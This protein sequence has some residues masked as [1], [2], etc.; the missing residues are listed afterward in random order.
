[1]LPAIGRSPS[2][3]LGLPVPAWIIISAVCIVLIIGAL[4]I[5]PRLSRG[6]RSGSEDGVGVVG[7]GN[8]SVG[9]GPAAG[10]PSSPGSAGAS[11]GPTGAP[12][13]GNLRISDFSAVQETLLGL[14]VGLGGWRVTVTIENP[15]GT[16]Q[17]WHNVS[18]WVTGGLDLARGSLTEGIRVY[19]SGQLVCA[20][21]TTPAAAQVPAHDDTT[22]QFRVGS[23]SA[24]RLGQLDDD[25]CVPPSDG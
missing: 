15:A 19:D 21:P 6:V 16:A 25:A 17:E 2:R 4:I 12:I 24:P 11:N 13:N 8:P 23:R 10:G 7:G 1:V 5:L 3:F 9:V 20:E 14:P 22:F 18:V